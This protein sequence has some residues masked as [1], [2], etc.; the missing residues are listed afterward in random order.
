MAKMHN[1]RVVLKR[2]EASKNQ[3]CDAEKKIIAVSCE[4]AK[5]AEDGQS[6]LGYEGTAAR[7]YFQG[8][9]KCVDEAFYFEK[10]SRR[11]P[12]DPFN[13]MLSF[14]YS[15]LLREIQVSLETHGLNSYFGFFH[16]DAEK[17]P[18]LACDLI[19]E[20]RAVI[21]D[22]TV[23]SAVN[24]HIIRQEHFEQ[25]DGK[26]GIYFTKEGVRIFI[27]RMEQKLSTKI[28]YLPYIDYPL[29]FRHAIDM[30]AVQL[31]KAMEAEDAS[32]YQPLWIR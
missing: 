16:R 15:M 6:L 30:Q 32:L 13:S 27:E 21:V 28:Q 4:K 3:D 10:R 26:P 24:K 11:P 14:G 8:M 23:M 1:Q 7:A 12:L 22:A 18:S 5:D 19:E 29:D 17:S 31:I 25:E 9:G 20:W 2:Y